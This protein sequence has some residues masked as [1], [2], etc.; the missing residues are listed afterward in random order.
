MST[1]VDLTP[2]LIASRFGHVEIVN[3][4]LEH[5]IDINEEVPRWGNALF[6]AS[7]AGQLEMVNELLRKGINSNCQTKLS[8]LPDV[9]RNRN[10]SYS[11]EGLGKTSLIVAVEN[12]HLEI[13]KTLLNHGMVS[14]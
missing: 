3:T 6:V 7:E 2:L 9:A 4:L 12:G 8:N 1:L 14:I 5:G 10:P 11:N 13:V